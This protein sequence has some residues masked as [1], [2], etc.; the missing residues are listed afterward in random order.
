MTT[1]VGPRP[2]RRRRRPPRRRRPRPPARLRRDARR[3]S[4]KAGAALVQGHD[5]RDGRGRA[6][7]SPRAARNRH[8]TALTLSTLV[9]HGFSGVRD[10]V[11]PD[12]LTY[13]ASALVLI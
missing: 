5:R 2:P 3:G 11:L 13:Y 4:R 7:G 1:T 12:W 6:R 10:P 8:H 9:A